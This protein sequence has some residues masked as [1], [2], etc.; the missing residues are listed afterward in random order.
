MADLIDR[1]EALDAMAKAMPNLTTPDGSGEFDRDIH[2]A[3]EA[4]VDCMQIINEL[5]SAQPAWIPCSERMPEYPFGCLV[6]VWDTNPITMDEFENILPYFVGWDGDQW[7]DSEGDQC[8][9]EVIAWMPLPEPFKE[10][11]DD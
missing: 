7:N 2:I 1:Q 4:F 11:R 10:D 6:T 5:P 3:D 8:P 9:F